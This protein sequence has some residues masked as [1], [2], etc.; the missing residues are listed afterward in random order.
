M[1]CFAE[2][3]LTFAF[4]LP[5]AGFAAF[6]CC[7]CPVLERYCVSSS[8]A[9]FSSS[10][11][12]AKCSS[13]AATF[14]ATRIFCSACCGRDG[15]VAGEREHTKPEARRERRMAATRKPWRRRS[16]VRG[17]QEG[18]RA[19]GGKGAVRRRHVGSKRGVRR[20]MR[21][22]DAVGA[23]RASVLQECADATGVARKGGKADGG[24][25]FL[26]VLKLAR[27]H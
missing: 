26:P 18:R 13:S 25:L 16:G 24:V 9:A 17:R 15:G 12:H 23:H 4:F 11:W 14:I 10:S 2:P 8:P 3:M 7:N 21:A 27:Q 22:M 20:E 19:G 1:D 6:W 5:R